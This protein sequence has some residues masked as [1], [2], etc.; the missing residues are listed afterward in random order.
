MNNFLLIFYIKDIK[1][2]DIKELKDDKSFFIFILSLS[3]LK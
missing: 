1:D 3:Q 2:L